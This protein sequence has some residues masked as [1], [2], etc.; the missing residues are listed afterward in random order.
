MN[1][2]LGKTIKSAVFIRCR[3]SA[4][5]LPSGRNTKQGVFPAAHPRTLERC[6]PISIRYY[7]SEAGVTEIQNIE[8]FD[9][10]V[11]ENKLVVVDFFADWCGPC[12]MIAPV[13]K[14]LSGEFSGIKFV[15]V[16]V[17]QNHELAS[18]YQVSSI[19]S[20]S[21]ISAGKPVDTLT[22]ANKAEL[23]TKIAKLQ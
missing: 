20:F 13:F 10:I 12:K 14:Q 21:F 3:R 16:N 18:R 1:S 8:Q 22:G 9:A 4:S 19:P 11:K 17:D 15:K 23:K 2:V 5:F 6:L 7:S